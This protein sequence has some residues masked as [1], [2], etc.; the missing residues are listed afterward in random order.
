M[1][2]VTQNRALAVRKLLTRGGVIEMSV[3]SLVGS[4]RGFVL[5]EGVRRT[6]QGHSSGGSGRDPVDSA[7]MPPRA[8]VDETEISAFRT[9]GGRRNQ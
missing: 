6:G 9:A 1:K 8:G 5:V 3:P 4:L 2:A 7:P